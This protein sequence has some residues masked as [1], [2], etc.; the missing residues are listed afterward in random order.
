MGGQDAFERSIASLH[1]AMLDDNRW[2][3]SSALI[4]EARALTGND[5]IVSEGP[6][7][8]EPVQDSTKSQETRYLLGK[9]AVCAG[10]NGSENGWQYGWQWRAKPKIENPAFGD[11]PAAPSAGLRL[12][13]CGASGRLLPAGA[14]MPT[15]V[16]RR[17]RATSMTGSRPRTTPMHW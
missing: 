16:R 7:G 6:P 3:G 2:P 9:S 15:L 13:R 1:D 12:A 11:H 8:C 5:L 14:I 10:Q 4:D 17:P